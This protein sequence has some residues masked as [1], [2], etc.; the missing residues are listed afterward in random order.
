[1]HYHRGYEPCRS[2]VD[3]ARMALPYHG[4]GAG[5]YAAN[6]DARRAEQSACNENALLATLESDCT[7]SR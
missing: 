1:V 5:W 7:A 3:G 6:D 4:R 2:A